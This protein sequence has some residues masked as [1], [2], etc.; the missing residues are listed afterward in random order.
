MGTRVGASV[1]CTH[2]H[3]RACEKGN[4][5]RASLMLLHWSYSRDGVYWPCSSACLQ[6]RHIRDKFHPVILSSWPKQ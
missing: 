3:P 4:G 2:M 5:A 6:W 1:S